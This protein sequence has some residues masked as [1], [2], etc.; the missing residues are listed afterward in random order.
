MKPSGIS[1]NKNDRPHRRPGHVLFA[2][3]VLVIIIAVAQGFFLDREMLA[4]MMRQVQQISTSGRPPRSPIMGRAFLFAFG[5]PLGLVL[6][7][8]SGLIASREPRAKT[9][10][11]LGIGLLLVF[12]MIIIPRI[13]GWESSNAY[14]G[15]GGVIVL[16]G[17]IA[18]FWLW[19]QHR[20]KLSAGEQSAA[21]W[22]ALGYL[23]FGIA[24]WNI[25]GFSSAPSFAL[26]P[27]KMIELGIRPFAVGQLKAIMAYLALGW[28]FTAI[29]FAKSLSLRKL[30][31]LATRPT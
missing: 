14:F 23:C 31:K 24:A 6:L 7:F 19:A 15:I 20:Q 30:G 1:H 17:L 27:E 10:R 16:I 4:N 26:F 13:F 12:L 5:L 11:S 21:D 8:V 2:V 28:T 22:K 9:R 18:V 3:G 25:C 29:G